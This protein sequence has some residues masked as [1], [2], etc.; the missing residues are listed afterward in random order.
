MIM[1]AE[2]ANTDLPPLEIF[3]NCMFLAAES[4]DSDLPLY[5]FLHRTAIRLRA[6]CTIKFLIDLVLSYL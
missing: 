1:G 4:G 2:N 3:C 6:V 5:R